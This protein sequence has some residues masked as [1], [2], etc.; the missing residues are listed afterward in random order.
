M[1]GDKPEQQIILR[2]IF[3][4]FKAFTYVVVNLVYKRNVWTVNCAE[5]L[6]LWKFKNPYVWELTEHLGTFFGETEHFSGKME[7]FSGEMK[8]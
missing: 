7:L 1:K 8:A 5:T 2:I 3:W 4:C 6:K